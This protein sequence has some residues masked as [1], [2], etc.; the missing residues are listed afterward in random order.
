LS[1]DQLLTKAILR[2]MTK[3]AELLATQKARR[4]QQM[5]S[6]EARAKLLSAAID[7]ICDRGFAETTMADV[8]KLAGFTRGAIQHHFECRD[9]LVLEIIRSVENQISDLFDSMSLNAGTDLRSRID[10]LIDSLG[11]ISRSRA[12]LAVVQI[13][14]STRSNTQF[15]DEVRKSMLRSSASFKRLWFRNFAGDVPAPA[16]ADC[17]RI[18]VTIMRGIV[19]SQVLISNNRAIDQMLETCKEMVRRQ[20][21]AAVANANSLSGSEPSI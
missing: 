18:V 15:D 12:Y 13:W 1:R 20:M 10:L 17:R 14:I 16:I 8:A 11:A 21:L 4:T 6:D 3:S 2:K 7:L 5:R 9:D 19:V